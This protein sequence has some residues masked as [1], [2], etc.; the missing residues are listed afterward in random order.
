MKKSN[1]HI[2]IAVLPHRLNSSKQPQEPDCARPENHCASVSWSSLSE[3]FYIKHKHLNTLT[4][5]STTK[6]SLYA[7]YG[8]GSMVV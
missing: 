4:K 1:E 5:I 8:D 2:S 7:L 3:Q 6:M